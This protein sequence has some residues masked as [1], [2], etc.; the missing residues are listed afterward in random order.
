MDQPLRTLPSLHMFCVRISTVQHADQGQFSGGRKL[1]SRPHQPQRSNGL[2][3]HLGSAGE[4]FPG[5]LTGRGW[6]VRV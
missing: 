3:P 6:V 1:V 5:R 4:R 2:I